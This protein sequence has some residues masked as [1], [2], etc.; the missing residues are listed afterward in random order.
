[1][2]NSITLRGVSNLAR[3]RAASIGVCL[4]TFAAL[5]V[6]TG[7]NAAIDITA[8]TTGITDA[9]TAVLAVI[10]AMITMAVAVWGVKKVLKFFGR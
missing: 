8:A 9:S 6:S 7:A 4:G 3:S 1:M 10:A 2:K 5:V